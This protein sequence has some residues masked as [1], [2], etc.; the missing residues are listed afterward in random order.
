M[1]AAHNSA[2]V[3]MACS[4]RMASNVLRASIP[5]RN[6]G[7][8]KVKRPGNAATAC[9]V[10]TRSSGVLARVGGEKNLLPIGQ[11]GRR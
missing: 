11:T 10:V 8:K 4:S 3:H 9:T 6:Q 1:T 7:G 5:Q 2:V